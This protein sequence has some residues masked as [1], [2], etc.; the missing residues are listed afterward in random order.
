M[1][2][3]HGD[4]AYRL[5]K[6]I[7]ANFS[8]NVY[9][10]G[11]PKEL[12]DIMRESLAFNISRYPE[13]QAESLQE[14]IA[15][16]HNLKPEQVL[17]SNGAIEAIYLIAQCFSQSTTTIFVPTFSEYED[18][19]RIFQH[20]ITIK[21]QHELDVLLDLPK[22]QTDLCFLCNPNNPNGK[23]LTKDRLLK[24]VEKN[25]QTIFVI[26]E[27]FIDFTLHPS[28]TIIS[29]IFNHKNLIVLRSMT[30]LFAIPGLRLG[31]VVSTQALIKTLNAFK[32]PWSVNA[33]AISAGT[34]I[35]EHYRVL[36][37]NIPALL[38][39]TRRFMAQLKALSGLAVGQSDV[40]FM[41]CE[42]TGGNAKDLKDYLVKRHGMLIRDA[43]NFRG[44]HEG[45]F[46]LATQTESQN[47]QLVSAILEWMS[48]TSR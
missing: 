25:E 46:R 29:E 16:H 12:S 33:F 31:Y 6:T 20:Q 10:G 7:I 36:L 41:L 42:L 43:S 9:Y 14:K 40:H 30:K 23:L 22:L 13:V 17:V 32:Q 38:E 44:S 5:G 2:Y 4:D 39:E 28:D 21:A 24:W 8:S 19:C 15:L 3:G 37:P 48:N 27:A 26:D 47:Q 11:P 18:A 34:Y 35:M 1:L 45:H